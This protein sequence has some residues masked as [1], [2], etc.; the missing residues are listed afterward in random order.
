MNELVERIRNHFMSIPNMSRE[1]CTDGKLKYLMLSIVPV[2]RELVASDKT[3]FEYLYVIP[4]GDFF[5]GYKLRVGVN[6]PVDT[7]GMFEWD[8]V[9]EYT[10]Y[11]KEVPSFKQVSQPQ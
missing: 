10:M 3:F 8:S 11:Y 6:E 9:K 7:I 1:E 4:I 2:Y 5:V